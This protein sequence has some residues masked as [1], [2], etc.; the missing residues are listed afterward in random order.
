[1]KICDVL[2]RGFSRRRARLG[3]L[4]LVPALFV[5]N[6]LQ[7]M[8]ANGDTRALHMF[9]NHTGERINVVYKRDG[10]YDREALRQID[11]FLRDWRK[12]QS[13]EMDPRLLDLVW[14]VTRDL[15]AS[16]PVHIICGY[17]SEGT[18]SM[19]RARSSGVAQHSQH[20]E[21]RAMDIAIPTVPAARL[22]EMGMLRQKGGVGY[23][24]QSNFVHLDVGNVRAWP[25]MT[26]DQLVRLFPR[27]ETLH[28]PSDGPP[29]P[30]YDVAL[31][32]L[33]RDGK[34]GEETLLAFADRQQAEPAARGVL[35]IFDTEP[36]T[37]VTAA[38]VVPPAPKTMAAK[39]SA[40]PL[41]LERPVFETQLAMLEPPVPLQRPASLNPV[42][43]AAPMQNELTALRFEARTVAAFFNTKAAERPSLTA[44]AWKLAARDLKA[45]VAQIK[46][47]TPRR[48]VK[49]AAFKKFYAAAPSIPNAAI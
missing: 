27:G 5:P 48:W 6:P 42:A 49:L 2:L 16:V 40:P 38:S 4:L 31:A 24:P 26:T 33:G 47:F 45:P 34:H 12:N 46:E 19:L 11:W 8:K 23:Y 35:E 44:P 41:P 37:P 25:R 14:E 20:T 13:I 36:A 15:G 10:R 30:G 29:L 43:S 3:L 18:N 32:R 39:Q 21:G 28:L 7:T 22:R 1:M 9:H 17:R